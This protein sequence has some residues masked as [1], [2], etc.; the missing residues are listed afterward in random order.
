M[1]HRRPI[2]L[3]LHAPAELRWG[4]QRRTLAVRLPY[5]YLHAEVDLTPEGKRHVQERHPG[6]LPKY[7]DRV[8]A[9]ESNQDGFVALHFCETEDACE[10]W[11]SLNVAPGCTTYRA[12]SFL[13][14]PWRVSITV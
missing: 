1:R 7:R 5:P 2:H 12:R 10:Q 4:L 9:D 11:V 3:R 14:R 13:Q 8:G 6:L